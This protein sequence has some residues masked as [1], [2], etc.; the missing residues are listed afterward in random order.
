MNQKEPSLWKRFVMI[1]QPYFFPDIPNGGWMMLLLL[2]MLLIFL[3]GVLFLIVSALTVGGMSFAPAVTA[4]VAEG[5]ATLVRG[6]FQSD[7]WLVAA[8]LLIV[9]V[10]VFGALR[11][12]LRTRWRAWTLLAVVL[13]LSLSVTGINVAFSYIGNYFSNAL[14]KKNEELAYLF[15]YV[16]FFGFLIGI[17]I[18]A[19][20]S[21]VQNYLGMRWREWLT[22]EFLGS[23]FRNRNYYEIETISHI[24]NP[25]Q[26]IMEDIRTFTRTSLGF[27][28][29]LLGSL[30]DLISFT[31]ILWSK[32][33]LLV[34]VVLGYSLVGTIM[35]VLI[36]RRLVRL[37]FNQ[38]R[39]EAD[40]RYSL[41][42]V[43][44]NA[45]SI[46]FYQG[47]K[48][49]ITHVGGRFRQVLRNFNLLIGWQR[50]LSFFTTAYSYI[51]VVLPF[52]VLFPEYFSGKIE[53]GD[54]VQANFAFLQVYGALSL[55]VSQIEQ[56][57]GF[58]AGVQ[59]L[60]SFAETMAPEK[61][62]APGIRS[63]DAERFSLKDVTLDTPD[64]SRTLIGHLSVALPPGE[65]LA[66]VGQ[67]GVGKS[68]LLRALAGLWTQGEGVIQRPDLK[69]IFF[70]PQRPYMLL[71]SLRDQLLYPK[72]E[73]EISEDELREI[74][75]TV[76][77]EDLP[78]RVGGFNVELDWAD[79]LSLGEQQ[80]LAFARL[81]VNRPKYA[82]LDEATS[83][84]DVE[85]EAI[86]YG[87]L[88]EL[89]IQYISV[90]HR[91]TILD[92]HQAVLKLKGED[93]WRL[94]PVADYRATLRL[95]SEA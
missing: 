85:N 55:I 95:P 40:F 9:P 39:Y 73:R 79:V 64:R 16:Y 22:G 8:G 62:R 43:R 25:D 27:L 66:I 38:L 41:V 42:H 52:L 57:T 54:M 17:P 63:E 77:L 5:L 31:G 80:R 13:L 18:V 3:S 45:E 65:N 58:A 47:E 20:Y 53:Y 74:L 2:T 32:S 92:Y 68:S 81:L 94:M 88:K 10:A 82:V 24:D 56:I 93:Q 19:F 29:I 91:S 1:A 60:S 51:P 21:Y 36:G 37:N 49:E 4:R 33:S 11:S 14:V 86:L 50:N 69:D 23:Y 28:L 59:R 72:L 35:T 34:A 44:D 90:G 78:E 46:A 67:S 7:L 89:G 61:A 6:I 87:K 83:A 12:H 75:K 71:G 48:P 15:V 76:N 84:L 26:R 70:L 30:M